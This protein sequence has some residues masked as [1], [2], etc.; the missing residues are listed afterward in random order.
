[1]S[2]GSPA[3]AVYSLMITSLNVRT[4]YNK[5]NHIEHEEKADVA[6][7]LVALQQTALE[8]TTDPRLLMYIPVDSKWT[9]VILERLG[10]RNAWTLATGFS[11]AWVVIAFAFTLIDSFVALIDSDPSNDGSEGVSVGVLW[12]WLLSLVIGWLWVPTF[13]FNEIN[14]ALRHA[15]DET[16]STATKK[17]KQHRNA[18]TRNIQGG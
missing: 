14:V 6:G 8:L 3:L 15:N 2:V 9:Q 10:E 18:E 1:M 7:A 11:V 4:V 12:L 16:V 5:V 13:P 17:L